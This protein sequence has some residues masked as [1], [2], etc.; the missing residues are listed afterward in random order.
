M[1]LPTTR[2]GNAGA[3]VSRICLGTMGFGARA[4]RPWVVEE[5]EAVPIIERALD[6]G[7]NFID[8]ADVYSVGQSERIVGKALEGR[9]DDVVL[10]TKVCNPM[11][12]GPNQRGLSRKHVLA[13]FQASLDRLGTSYVDLYQIH[14]FDPDTHIDETLSTLDR[15]VDDGGVRYLGAS[16]MWAW[17]FALMLSRQRERGWHRFATMQNHY[18]LVYRE[19]EREMM[20]LCRSQGVGVIPWSPL[21]RGFLAGPDKR[22]KGTRAETDVG[23]SFYRHAQDEEIARRVDEMADQKGVTSAQIALAWLLHQPGVVAPIVGVT[24]VE[25]VDDAVAAVDVRLT[26]EDQRWLAQPYRPR[27]VAG[28]VQ[29]DDVPAE[30]LDESETT[31][32]PTPREH[33]TDQELPAAR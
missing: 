30:H 16:T 3:K 23:R 32:V 14:R 5:K 25:Q 21:A 10:A 24:K 2:L 33:Q 13:G 12:R 28:W 6:L 27:G 7:I 19:E 22:A 17:Q 20:P 11:G 29:G 8:T 26:D 31:K 9:R 18:N 15:L 1:T 4:W